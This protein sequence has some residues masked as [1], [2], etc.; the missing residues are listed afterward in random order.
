MC[1]MTNIR[2]YTHSDTHAYN[3]NKSKI[4]TIYLNLRIKKKKINK[5]IHFTCIIV[6]V[7]AT[8]LM[9]SFRQ[10]QKHHFVSAFMCMYT[11]YTTE[12]YSYLEAHKQKR[13][14]LNYK[15]DLTS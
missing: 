13:K 5:K 1:D 15:V 4:Y 6:S 7:I 9:T 11:F 12:K 3:L 14:V 2:M 8:A 10:R